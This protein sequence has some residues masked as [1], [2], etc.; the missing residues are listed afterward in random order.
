MFT[1]LIP[2]ITALIPISSSLLEGA[3]IAAAL[4]ALSASQWVNLALAAT[5]ALD[6]QFY[7]TMDSELGGLWKRLLPHLEKAVDL[8]DKLGPELAGPMLVKEYLKYNGQKAIEMA[9]R[10]N[11]DV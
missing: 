4:S 7:S 6:P 8:V 5:K 2:L 10:D 11:K 1:A 3:T 9:D